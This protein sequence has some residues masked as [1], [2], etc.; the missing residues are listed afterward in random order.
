MTKSLKQRL[1]WSMV[2]A[3][4]GVLVSYGVSRLRS[5]ML[6]E[7]RHDR[8]ERILGRALIDSMDCSDP[9]AKY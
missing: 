3:A 9:V 8:D 1:L 5:K 2:T 6:G 4:A 7:S